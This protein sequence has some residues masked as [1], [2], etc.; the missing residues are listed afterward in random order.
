M[1]EVYSGRDWLS[2]GKLGGSHLPA[3]AGGGGQMRRDFIG[4]YTG[5]ASVRAGLAYMVRGSEATPGYTSV[6]PTGL[7][8]VTSEEEG[9]EEVVREMRF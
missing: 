7:G 2:R 9:E 1:E 5:V 6:A 4:A 8:S 3:T